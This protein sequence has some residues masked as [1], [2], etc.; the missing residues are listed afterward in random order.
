MREF[1]TSCGPIS[2]SLSLSLSF[3]LSLPC[4]ALVSCSVAP[5]LTFRL[6]CHRALAPASALCPALLWFSLLAQTMTERTT[7]LTSVAT[8]QSD[9]S[10]PPLKLA[11]ARQ[12]LLARGRRRREGSVVLA[13]FRQW[14][15]CIC[16]CYRLDKEGE[17]PR[18]L[19]RTE[20]LP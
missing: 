16:V 1:C 3:P 2:L 10:H 13:P 20:V 9:R 6:L 19:G 14:S 15:R 12:V 18:G 7:G 4:K 5:H 17:V 8:P 11:H